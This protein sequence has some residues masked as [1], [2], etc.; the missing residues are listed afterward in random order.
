MLLQVYGLKIISMERAII[1]IIKTNNT[2]VG[3]RIINT[4]FDSGLNYAEIYVY[5]R[6]NINPKFVSLTYS[7]S[8]PHAN[9][10]RLK[11][12]ESAFEFTENYLHELY[13]SNFELE[14]QS[15]IKV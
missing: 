10:N 1:H 3:K 15:D 6:L 5:N 12:L 13:D 9:W 4:N 2:E 8:I 11:T 14:P 7:V